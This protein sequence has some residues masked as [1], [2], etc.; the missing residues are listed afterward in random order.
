MIPQHSVT[1]AIVYYSSAAFD[2]ER[3]KAER[4]KMP[5]NGDAHPIVRYFS[6]ETR[7][8]LD[9][10]AFVGGDVRTAREYLRPGHDLPQWNGQRIRPALC[11][12]CRDLGGASGELEAFRVGYQS[13]SLAGSPVLP[14]GASLTEQQLDALADQVGVPMLCEIGRAFLRA[15]EAPKAAEKKP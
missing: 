8:D 15:S 9:A 14:I 10:P 2:V 6:G 13:S 3:V 7:L 1:A 5:D 12:R 11:A 4:A